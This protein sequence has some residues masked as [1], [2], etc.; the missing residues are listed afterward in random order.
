MLVQ[1]L[2]DVVAIAAGQYHSLALR[3][4]GTVWAWGWNYYGQL[5]DGTTIDRTTP[6]Q[7]QGL[8]NVVAIAASS[9]FSLALKADGTVWAWGQNSYGQ[10]GDGTI[11]NKKNPVQVKNTSNV[12]YINAYR[13]T[14]CAVKTDGT[15]WGWGEQSYF[16]FSSSVYSGA[17]TAPVQVEGISQATRAYLLP[18][19][20]VAITGSTAVDVD[21]KIAEGT[22][23]LRP[24]MQ[25]TLNSVFNMRVISYVPTNINLAVAGT[26]LVGT[27][28]PNKKIPV[29]N[30]EIRITDEQG[31]EVC[32]WQ[33]LD[34]TGVQ[35]IN[36]VVDGTRI[37]SFSFRVQTPED[38][39]PQEYRGKITLILSGL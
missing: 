8:T 5:G 16:K 11:I 9:N 24:G 33:P 1:G 30:M 34:G 15:V 12:R 13:N 6:V 25:D 23:C 37:Y 2:T 29:G 20:L 22:R 14:A 21:R 4:D 10:L 28:D 17:V 19:G 7:V 27:N 31:R 38:C 35:A 3:S 39:T 26:D 18:C 32:P 36:E